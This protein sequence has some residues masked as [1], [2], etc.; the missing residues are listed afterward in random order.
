MSDG[1]V[2]VEPALLDYQRMTQELAEFHPSLFVQGATR[3][4]IS[5]DVLDAYDAPYP[6]ETFCAGAR[7]LPLLMGLTPGSECARQNRRTLDAL[8]TY[9]RP[10]LTAFSD[11]DPATQGWEAVL[12]GAAPGAAGQIHP[13][14]EGAGHFLQEDKGPELG[15]VI[16]NFVTALPR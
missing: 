13:V 15:R 5:P 10:F 11:A 1:R 4:E 3:S 2:A 7:Q 12:R 16:A 8:R 6:D 9:D 14:I